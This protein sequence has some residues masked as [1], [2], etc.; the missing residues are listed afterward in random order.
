[1]SVALSVLLLVMGC[2]G[3]DSVEIIAGDHCARDRSETVACTRDGDTVEV[4]VCGGEAV[5]LLGINS[6]EIAHDGTEVDECFGPEA[7]AWMEERLVGVDVRLEF[8]ATC[9]DTYGRTLAYVWTTDEDGEESLLNAEILRAGYA[10]VYEDFSD[11]RLIDTL[12]AAQ[13]D[14]Q[15]TNSGLWAVCE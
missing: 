15:A 12:R 1:M 5:R 8:D 11:I 7:A 13:E 10:R 2:R 6:P 14:A 3:L 9:A 4:G